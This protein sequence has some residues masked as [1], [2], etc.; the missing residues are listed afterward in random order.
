VWP[1]PTKSRVERTPAKIWAASG[2]MPEVREFC[3]SLK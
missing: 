3:L 2:Q 1:H